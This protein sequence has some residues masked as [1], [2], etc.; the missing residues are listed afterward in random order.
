[1]MESIERTFSDKGGNHLLVALCFCDD[2]YKCNVLNIPKEYIDVE[3]ADISITKAYVD[4]PIHYSV[5]FRM[6]A[7]LLEEFEKQDN[8]IYTFICSTDELDTNHSE[9]LP[10]DFRW[11]LFDTLF[12]R[13]KLPQN[14][15][16]QDVIVG[17]PEYQSLG[18]AFYHEKHAPIV[19]IVASYLEEKQQLFN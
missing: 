3:I 18:R 6:C 19:H 14:V 1:M 17:P 2:E 5:F 9:L 4:Q 13:T 16:V 11:N 8:T 10:Q 12:R 7:W 15:L